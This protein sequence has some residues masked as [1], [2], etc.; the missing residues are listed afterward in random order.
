MSNGIYVAL[1]GALVQQRSLDVVANNAAN[2]ATTGFRADRVAFREVLSAADDRHPLPNSLHY[3]VVSQVASDGRPGSLRE[4][5]NPYDLALKGRGVLAVQ[6]P[7]GERYTRAGAFTPDANGTLRN[8][9]GH[10]LLNAGGGEVQ[11]PPHA[12]EVRIDANGQILIGS[13]SHGQLA[14]GLFPHGRVRVVAFDDPGSLVKEGNSYF[15][16]TAEPHD[17]L[18]TEVAQGYL[19]GANLNAVAAMNELITVSR[20]FEAL[21]KVIETFQHMD[22]RASRELGSRAGG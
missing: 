6:T 1:S 16:A 3:A 8:A 11:I 21:Q 20:S 7:N 14:D 4:T 22:E 19:E 2:T 18:E 15:R 5:G 9:E 10:A 13:R 12:T 17:D